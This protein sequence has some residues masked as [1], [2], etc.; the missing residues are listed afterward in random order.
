MQNARLERW[1]IASCR[2]HFFPQVAKKSPSMWCPSELIKRTLFISGILALL[3]ALLIIATGAI[4]VYNSYRYTI[5]PVSDGDGFAGG[6]AALVAPCI[7]FS[8]ALYFFL[9]FAC[10]FVS[11]VFLFQQTYLRICFALMVVVGTESFFDASVLA[12]RHDYLWIWIP[13]ARILLALTIIYWL[14][15]HVLS[16]PTGINAC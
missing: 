13:G 9:F 4:E 3:Q 11:A 2:R 16:E 8:V 5:I 1:L 6:P 7:L 10:S 12:L 15:P 14:K